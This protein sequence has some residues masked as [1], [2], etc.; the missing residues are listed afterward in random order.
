MPLHLSIVDLVPVS[1]LLKDAAGE[2][3]S[4]ELKGVKSQGRSGYPESPTDIIYKLLNRLYI[5]LE[6]L[7]IYT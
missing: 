5:K 7:V 1:Q 6:A 2:L 3:G 4:G